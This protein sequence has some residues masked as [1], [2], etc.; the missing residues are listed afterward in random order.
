V[1][2]APDSSPATP[3]APRRAPPSFPTR[4]SRIIRDALF[5]AAVVAWV[6]AMYAVRRENRARAL[7]EAG[8]GEL[9]VFTDAFEQNLRLRVTFKALGHSVTGEAIRRT[10]EPWDGRLVVRDRMRVRGLAAGLPVVAEAYL[11][12]QY[13]RGAG[14]FKRMEG[15]L[16]LVVPAIIDKTFHC[17]MVRTRTSSTGDLLLIRVGE[18]GQPLG[19]ATPV[20]LPPDAR[21]SIDYFPPAQ[22]RPVRVGLRWDTHAAGST[23][24]EVTR[25]SV[26]VV[27]KGRVSVAGVET[28]AYRAVTRIE[29]ETGRSVEAGET[30]YDSDGRAL[31]QTRRIYG[32]EL[33]LERAERLAASDTEFEKLAMPEGGPDDGARVQ[34]EAGEIHE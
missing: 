24:G 17:T 28:T 19:R 9:A 22:I 6:G 20:K 15:L 29:K 3:D 11:E 14:G 31:A 25:A 32:L 18:A 16:R 5:A 34:D 23:S 7:S 1:S 2:A 10:K 21:V 4:R 30:W 27:E 33:T 8:A 13:D 12:T 26:E